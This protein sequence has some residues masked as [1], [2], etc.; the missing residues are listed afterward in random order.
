MPK[1]QR[2]PT[3]T[4]ADKEAAA[5]LKRHWLAMPNRPTQQ[6]LAEAWPY[7]G[8]EA[9][10]SLISQYMGGRIALNHRAVLFFANQLGLRPE[11][12][13][14]DLPELKLDN[15]IAEAPAEWGD[16]ADVRGYA[17]AT[18]LGAGAEADEY[19][20][21]HKLKFRAASLRR[22]G[23]RPQHLVVYYGKGDSMEPRIHDGDAI[24]FD[25]SDITPRDGAVF[26]VQRGREM[27]AK[28][29]E[30][31][32]GVV[33][34]RS[35]NPHGDHHWRKAKRADNLREPIQILGRVRWIG[36]WED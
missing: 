27:Y 24:L 16:W 25:T 29:C 14:S 26:I 8:T 15:R 19:A 9:N 1:T 32:D 34:F 31:L 20:E 3:V 7:S 23:L 5:R 18:G 22:K 30:V 13:R 4:E 28:R 12:I 35:D 6:A 17:Q 33:Y 21:S 11:D 10:Q 36:S 2:R